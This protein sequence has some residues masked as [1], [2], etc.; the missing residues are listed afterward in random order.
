MSNNHLNCPDK[1]PVIQFCH[2]WL[3]SA[4]F[5]LLLRVLLSVVLKA[6]YQ[7]IS[8]KKSPNNQNVSLL[9]GNLC[10]IPVIFS[11]PCCLSLWSWVLWYLMATKYLWADFDLSETKNQRWT[12]NVG[13]LHAR[14]N[15]ESR[16]GKQRRT[17]DNVVMVLV[18]V[19]GE[20]DKFD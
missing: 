16:I 4:A 6:I 19:G 14:T 1:I 2:L 7:I 13:R 17:D 9:S 15:Y 3:R 8:R 5:N 20:V 12:E 10:C 11:S 18:L